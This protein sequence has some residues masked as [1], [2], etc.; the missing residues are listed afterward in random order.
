MSEGSR[1]RIFSRLNTA[2]RQTTT[3]VSQPPALPINTYSQKEKVVKLKTL[4]EAMRTEVHIT[5]AKNWIAT[6]VDVL[7][8][9]EV[10]SL[11]YA[12]RTDIGRA[13]ELQRENAAVDKLQL[14]PYEN[15]IEQLKETVFNVEAGITSAAGA[16]AETGALIL[17]P[18]AKEPRLMSIVPSI[19]IAVLQ[20][21]TIHS[22]LSEVLQKENWPTKMPEEFSRKYYAVSSSSPASS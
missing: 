22:T 4:M 9:R 16:I 21:N 18:S 3:P 2:T 20:A 10:K 11:L 1:D 19:H 8:K 12:P 15:D 7:K 5:D 14:I 6:V 13:L 17:W